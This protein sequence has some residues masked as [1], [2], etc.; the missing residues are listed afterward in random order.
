MSTYKLACPQ[1]SATADAIASV[2]IQFDG[3]IR[4]VDWAYEPNLD[5]A[6]ENGRAEVSFLSVSSFASN[7][8]RGSI[9]IARQRLSLLTAE[10]GQMGVSKVVAGLNIP[11]SAGERLYLHLGGNC[12]HSCDVYVHVDDQA[13]VN[14]RRR[15]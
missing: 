11:V 15:R 8:A 9:S 5:A 6:D 4:V 14:L 13:N 7:D 3:V 2:D 12:T 1:D 10:A